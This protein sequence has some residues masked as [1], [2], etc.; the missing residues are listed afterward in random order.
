MKGCPNCGVDFDPQQ[1]RYAPDGTIVCVACGE[2]YAAAA[3]AQEAKSAGS[4]LAGAFGALLISLMSFVVRHG[5]IFFL[6]PLIGIVGGVGTA[7]VALKNE[8]AIAALGWKRIP[9]LVLGASAALFG[10]LSLILS[11]K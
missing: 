11:L 8:A 9:T 3:K 7:L 10:L 2:R 1:G 6:F 4:A 5:L